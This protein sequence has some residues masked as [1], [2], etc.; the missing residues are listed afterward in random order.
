MTLNN[1]RV[2]RKLCPDIYGT[3]LSFLLKRNGQHDPK[4]FWAHWRFCQDFYLAELS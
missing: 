1:F 3:E 2:G 4:N